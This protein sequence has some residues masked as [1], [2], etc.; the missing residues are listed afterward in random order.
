MMMIIIMIINNTPPALF[1]SWWP[2]GAREDPGRLNQTLT[3]GP[4]GMRPTRG[5]MRGEKADR[6]LRMLGTDLDLSGL[7]MG[8]LQRHK[9][10]TTK[11]NKTNESD[12]THVRAG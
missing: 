11:V 3:E 6:G 8:Q 5:L 4:L 10:T 1:V 12:N 2:H 9:P 7:V